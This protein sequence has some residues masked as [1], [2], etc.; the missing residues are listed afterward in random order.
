MIGFVSFN[1]A[2]FLAR[3]FAD[4]LLEGDPFENWDAIT[5][6]KRGGGSSVDWNIAE[7]GSDLALATSRTRLAVADF[8]KFPVTSED[9]NLGI[10][11]VPTGGFF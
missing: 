3:N 5:N 4:C 8:D 10:K 11:Q 2:I 1:E 7:D 6:K 9:I